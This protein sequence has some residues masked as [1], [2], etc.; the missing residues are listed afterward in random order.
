MA[1][2]L[3]L[4]LA[5]AEL[6]RRLPDGEARAMLAAKKTLLLRPLQR[7]L[8]RPHALGG[9]LGRFDGELWRVEGEGVVLRANPADFLTRL[10]EF[11]DMEERPQTVPAEKIWDHD[12]EILEHARGFYAEV[13]RRTGVR[14]W[15]ELEELFAG[16]L[17]RDLCGG[18]PVLWERC[19]AFHRGFRVGMELL[20]LLPRIGCRSGFLQVG[21][22]EDLRPVFP[23]RFRDPRDMARSIQALAPLPPASADEIVAPSG[24]TFYAREAPH[25]PALVEEGDHFETGQPLFVIEVMKMFNKVR[26]PFPGTVVENRMRDRDGTVVK[27]G[28]VIF[29][30]EPD[31]RASQESP[32]AARERVRAATLAL[33]ELEEG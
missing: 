20:L 21:V 6:G 11:L 2:E 31:Q 13:A 9:F 18:D 3:D 8:G 29:K 12:Q 15:P 23:E 25:L 27:K 17:S 4:D 24:G 33:L 10:Y 19:R 22:A 30:I 16:P 1:R 32:E 26:A 5:L 28:E 7:L 14:A